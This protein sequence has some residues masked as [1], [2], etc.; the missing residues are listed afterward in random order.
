MCAIPDLITYSKN[1]SNTSVLY[2]I[3]KTSFYQEFVLHLQQ[4]HNLYTNVLVASSKNQIVHW[5]LFLFCIMCCFA[6]LIAL[7]DLITGKRAYFKLDENGIISIKQ[8]A[9]IH[10]KD[11]DH[12]T[13][14]ALPGTGVINE[15]T[16]DSEQKNKPECI[17]VYI[18]K[19]IDPSSLTK[20]QR[21]RYRALSI[22]HSNKQPV[23]TLLS[24]NLDMSTVDLYEL[25]KAK[26]E[27]YGTSA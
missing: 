23:I 27:K 11:I 20:R 3:V 25:M 8:R 26:L 7:R 16:P 24:N 9:V 13:C 18:K 22:A 5:I 15:M 1:V 21:R 14:R 10:W 4:S 6:L 17:K 12:I 19:N 2:P